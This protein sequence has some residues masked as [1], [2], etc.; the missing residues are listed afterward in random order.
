MGVPFPVASLEDRR[1]AMRP[2]A[3]ANELRALR[4]GAVAARR[5]S[6]RSAA[7]CAAFREKLQRVRIRPA[8]RDA[9]PPRD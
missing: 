3:S 9:S 7:R 5:A 2:K 8:P 4:Q 1:Q 6:A